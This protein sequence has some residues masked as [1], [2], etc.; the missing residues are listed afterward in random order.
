[1]RETKR[2]GQEGYGMALA[3]TIIGGLAVAGLVL[4]L[5]LMIGLWASGWQWI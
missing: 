4:Y 1:M 2:T 3:G 5:L